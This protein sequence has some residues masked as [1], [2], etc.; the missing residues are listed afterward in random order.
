MQ[1]LQ[2]SLK[3]VSSPSHKVLYD[4]TQHEVQNISTPDS[5]GGSFPKRNT[6]AL[7]PSCTLMFLKVFQCVAFLIMLIQFLQQCATDGNQH[8]QL[9]NGSPRRILPPL[10]HPVTHLINRDMY[11]ST[12]QDSIPPSLSTFQEQILL[13]GTK[14][15]NSDFDISFLIDTV[16]CNGGECL[17]R[18]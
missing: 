7:R 6:T 14:W 4:G 12:R 18:D 9:L 16:V 17:E 8:D 11:L 13:R 1:D 3:C 2:R 5:A 10:S 15:I